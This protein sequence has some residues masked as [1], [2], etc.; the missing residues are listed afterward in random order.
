MV[1]FFNDTPT[2]Q[3]GLA[4][5]YTLWLKRRGLMQGSNL[6]GYKNSKL[7]FKPRKIPPKSKIGRKNE[8][9]FS[10]KYAPV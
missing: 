3:A 8:Q 7:I 2:G 6:F 4:D 9:K 1:N 10:A 5:F